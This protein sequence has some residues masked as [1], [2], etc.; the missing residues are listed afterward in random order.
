[1]LWIIEKLFQEMSDA[2]YAICL[3][4]FTIVITALPSAI[5]GGAAVILWKQYQKR[6]ET[7]VL[8]YK[9]VTLALK[10]YR[11]SISKGSKDYQDHQ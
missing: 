7:R 11:E 3:I 4:V 1:M 10:A 9:E 6:Y 5:V 8:L 2:L